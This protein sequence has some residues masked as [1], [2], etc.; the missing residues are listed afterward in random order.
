MLIVDK[1]IKDQEYKIRL[2]NFVSSAFPK[3]F[4][5]AEKNNIAFYSKS[6][7]LDNCSFEI[8]TSGSGIYVQ[9]F[10]EIEFE[11]NK[12]KIYSFPKK[13]CLI[14]T[15]YQYHQK[16]NLNGLFTD[17]IV[18]LEKKL[19]KEKYLNLLSVLVNKII[20]R[21]IS[22]NEKNMPEHIQ[23]ILVLI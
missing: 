22:L 6:L 13:T 7:K 10:S 1:F 12:Y 2:C 3:T 21:K 15:V 23:K 5:K 20:Q 17:S 4:V 11:N 19:P 8:I 18:S 16:P 9:F 14:R